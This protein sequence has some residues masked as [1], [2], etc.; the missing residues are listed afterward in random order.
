M[1]EQLSLIEGYDGYPVKDDLPAVI[2]WL[3]HMNFSGKGD[4]YDKDIS[5]TDDLPDQREIL[6]SPTKRGVK[7]LTQQ[8]LKDIQKKYKGQ[9]ENLGGI[10][11]DDVYGAIKSPT[12]TLR[13]LDLKRLPAD[14]MAFYRCFH[15]PPYDQ[16]GI[17]LLVDKLIIYHQTL[18]AIIGRLN[19]FSPSTLMHYILFEIFNH[20]FFHHIAESTATSLEIICA[21]KGNPQP[22]FM[23]YWK[24][25]YLEKEKH[26][27]APLE[28]ALANAYAFNSLSFITRVGLGYKSGGVKIFQAAIQKYWER[29]PPGYKHARNYTQGQYIEGGAHLLGLM[30]N[31]P[32][33]LF[34]VPLMRLVRS[35]M[36]RG[37]SA[38][39]AKP[40]IPTYL[41][42]S[43][44]NL[45][46]FYKLVPTPNE[47]YTRLYWPYNTS[48]IDNF[49]KA[50]K[51]K[52]KRAKK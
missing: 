31:K 38:F 41:V 24:R 50:E 42:G 33:G 23:D 44:N 19:L 9:P 40:D 15:F 11:K 10:K 43:S 16:W 6:A 36:P 1:S 8:Q 14:A 25:K 2:Q 29:E 28:E 48:E 21:A 22:I 39:V 13:T 12:N 26:P 3:E 47:A 5:A 7:K 4:S 34:E 32:N 18:S 46:L 49:I 52:E 51:E 30:L 17:Y 37:F 27:H 20:E 35:V 45:E